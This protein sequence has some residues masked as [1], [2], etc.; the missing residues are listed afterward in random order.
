MRPRLVGSE[1][2][3]AARIER[4]AAA[5]VDRLIC[6]PVHMDKGERMHT[7]DRL[8]DLAGVAAPA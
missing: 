6:S 7:I 4:L 1:E 5:G 3:V 2:E 8:A